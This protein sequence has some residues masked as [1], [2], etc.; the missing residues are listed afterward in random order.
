MKQTLTSLH[1]LI[2][3]SFEKAR[4]PEH[5]DPHPSQD[6][7]FWQLVTSKAFN[8]DWHNQQMWKVSQLCQKQ[9]WV[10]EFK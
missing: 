5:L 6:G 3:S 9:V 1:W 4:I 2:F 8:I 10:E 7:Q